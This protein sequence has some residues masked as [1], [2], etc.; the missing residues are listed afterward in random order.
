MSGWRFW[1]WWRSLPTLTR[2]RGGGGCFRDPGGQ[3]VYGPVDK[4]GIPEPAGR[5]KV[6][7]DT[8][9]IL[10]CL[11]VPVIVGVG[12]LGKMDDADRQ[13][14]GARITTAAVQEVLR[15]HGLA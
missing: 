7:G 10:N 5:Y 6:E 14:E 15:H 8:V 13:E 9:D 3:R 12:D 1:A 11:D 4:D 2:W